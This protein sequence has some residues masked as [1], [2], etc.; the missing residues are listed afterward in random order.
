MGKTVIIPPVGLIDGLTD[1][2]GVVRH[3]IDY[4]KRG[5]DE[6]NVEGE[7]G[8]NVCG[9]AY[10]VNSRFSLC[11]VICNH[12]DHIFRNSRL[13]TVLSAWSLKDNRQLQQYRMSDLDN[14]FIPVDENCIS[15]LS[16][17]W[18]ETRE[19][20]EST[21]EVLLC[22]LKLDVGTTRR[23]RFSFE[24]FSQRSRSTIVD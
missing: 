14:G 3:W 12:F 15:R 21:N 8:L 4:Y 23:Q 10:I 22:E 11:S 18:S 6:E 16:P 13:P 9:C 17:D 2:H 20:Y 7:D 19:E 1:V 24:N 5:C